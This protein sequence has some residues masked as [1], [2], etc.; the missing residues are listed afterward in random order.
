[1][2]SQARYLHCEWRATRF[3]SLFSARALA[4]IERELVQ[5]VERPPFT[6]AFGRLSRPQRC[7]GLSK[8]L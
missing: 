1:M 3:M 7:D 4:L 8:K 6:G 5:V 2:S